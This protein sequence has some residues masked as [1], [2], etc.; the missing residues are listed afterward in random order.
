MLLCGCA[1]RT[2]QVESQ[3]ESSDSDMA[4]TS[5]EKLESTPAL[6]EAEFAV[7]LY[8]GQASIRIVTAEGRVIYIDPYARDDYGLSADLILVTHPHYDHDKVDKVQ[9]RNPG[10]E[11]VIQSEAIRN[12]EHQI[13][14]FGYVTVEA[15]EAGEEIVIE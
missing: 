10:C 11:V 15:V 4:E 14:D 13:F 8:Q 12:G 1:S 2:N 9:K 5:M 6:Q 3:S 7:L